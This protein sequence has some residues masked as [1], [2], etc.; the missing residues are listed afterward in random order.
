M[1]AGP[2]SKRRSTINC[3]RCGHLEAKARVC[4]I[5]IQCRRCSYRFEA[6]IGPSTD[7]AC[8]PGVPFGEPHAKDVTKAD[9]SESKK[10]PT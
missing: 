1:A 7:M 6:V 3:P 2:P 4:D 5:E 8:E 9:P 10:H